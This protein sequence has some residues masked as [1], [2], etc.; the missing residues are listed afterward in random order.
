MPPFFCM[1]A[2]N[3]CLPY[4]ISNADQFGMFGTHSEVAKQVIVEHGDEV[5]VHVKGRE[6]ITTAKLTLHS[7]LM[8][9]T[10]SYAFN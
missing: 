3:F 5:H 2:A 1:H 9:E 4:Q 10:H 8:L 7:D 6:C